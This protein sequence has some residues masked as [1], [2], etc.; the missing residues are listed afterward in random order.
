MPNFFLLGTKYGVNDNVDITPHL[1]NKNVVSVE[2]CRT[3]DLT[4]FYN[5]SP[6]NIREYVTR[7]GYK[8][9]EA[10]QMIKFLSI[11][12][13]DFFALKLI[14]SPL[15]K[16]ARLEIGGYGRVLQRDG[17]I[18]K[19]ERELYPQ[20]LGHTLQVEF[21]SEARLSLELGYGQTVHHI[22]DPKRIEQI[23]SP[24]SHLIR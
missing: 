8:G 2:F 14:G 12:D 22:T 9:F 18:Y 7:R 1:F 17:S 11:Q 13:G 16:K 23:F 5:S 24:I 6:L 10:S 4:E 19:Y 20:G 21:L 3:L 15:R